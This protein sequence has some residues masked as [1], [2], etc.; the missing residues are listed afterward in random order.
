MVAGSE[1]EVLQ[2][3]VRGR[4]GLIWWVVLAWKE[5][6]RVLDFVIKD[7]SRGESGLGTYKVTSFR[8]GDGEGVAK[9]EGCE[10][11]EKLRRGLTHRDDV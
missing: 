10:Q 1:G 11:P 4:P 5:C 7:K 3:M 6:G 9:A 2:V 8:R